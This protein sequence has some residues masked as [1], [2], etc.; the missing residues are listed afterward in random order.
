MPFRPAGRCWLCRVLWLSPNGLSDAAHG[1]GKSF[2]RL[3]AAKDIGLDATARPELTV[4]LLHEAHD[5]MGQ[6]VC[7]SCCCFRFV[8]SHGRSPCE[9][10]HR[11]GG[12]G[13]VFMPI[14]QRTSCAGFDRDPETA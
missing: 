10:S 2:E 11:R 1:N 13:T 8:I 7:P 14:A 9:K 5:L 12:N 3:V 6:L 4:R